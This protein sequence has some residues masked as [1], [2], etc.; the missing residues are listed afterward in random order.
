MDDM[1]KEKLA[2]KAQINSLEQ[3]LSKQIKEKESLLQTLTVFKSESKEKEDKYIENEIDLEKK[4]KELDNIIYKVGQSAQTKAQ[5]IKQ[6]LYDGIIISDKHVVLLVIDDEETLIF[7]EVSR[8]K[9]SE[10]EKDPEAVKQSISHKPF[11][12]VKL[13]QLSE[14]FGKRFTPQQELLAEQAF[15]FRISNPT[16]ES[17]NKSP[18]KVEVP[19]Q[20]PKVSLVNA[21]LKKL[22]LH[23]AQFDSVVKKRITPNARTEE[24]RDSLNDE[25]NLKCAVNEDLNAQIQDK[26][27]VITSLKNDLQK[28]KGKEIVDIAAQTPSAYTIVP[29]M[30]KLDFK[31]L[32]PSAKKVAVTPKTK[33]KKVRFAKPFT[34]S[35]N[36]KQG[37]NATDIPSSSSLV[38]IVRFE[39]DHLARI[40]G[41]GDYQLGNVTISRVYYIKG[42]AH[43]LFSVGQF[44]NTD[45]EVAFRKNTCFICNLEG[46]DL[47]SGSRVTNLY[48]ISLDDML[49]TS[50]IC[51][52]SKASKTKSWLWHRRSRPRLHSMTPATSSSGLVLNLVSQQPC[53]SPKRG[54]WDHSFQPMFAEYFNPPT[55]TISL[56]PVAAAPRAV[57][58]AD[59][60][61]S[62][63]IDEDAPSISIPSTQEQEHSPNISQGFEESP[64][65]HIFIMIHFMKTRLLKDRHQM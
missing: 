10:K 47:V 52:L 64:K 26:V 38:M 9:M 58:L 7:K 25:L 30:F 21:S 16:I 53:I 34:S 44:C 4:I 42:I 3:N 11:D 39:N 49:K 13:N 6:T 15:G 46:V 55:I 23:L 33:I 36:I 61:V 14:D 43:N 29:G 5:R 54:D 20:L 35:S 8:S 45:L 24:Q 48:I 19:S 51:L 31:S 56:V 62:T 28:L 60:S 65:N 1:I 59:S 18:V 12:Y 40:M 41:Y 2:L 17:S 32:A 57:D 63:L 22:K 50:S 37:S 27:F